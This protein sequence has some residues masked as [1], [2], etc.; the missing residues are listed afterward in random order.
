MNPTAIVAALDRELR[1]LVRGW[2]QVSYC[3]D[4]RSFTFYENASLV[5]VAGGIG[6]RASE[7]AARASVERYEPSI[8]ISA[9]L[10]GAL[11]HSLKVGSIITPNVIVDGLSGE[12]YRCNMGGGVIG[13]GILVSAGQVAGVA[14]KQ[15]LA[16]RFHALA[17]DMEAAGVAAVAREKH[18]LFRCV[19][20]ISDEADFAMPPLSRFVDEEGRLHTGRFAAW[21][22]VRPAVW[23][24]LVQLGRNSGLAAK[25][26]AEWLQQHGTDQVNAGTVVKLETA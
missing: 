11:I 21:A 15:E 24:K 2:K 25:A 19:K 18:L 8:L 26:L 23:W 10:A 9:G 4:G 12:E 16:A 7:R 13:G 6:Q 22:S 1:P 14:S 17:V 3:H 5:A 20:A